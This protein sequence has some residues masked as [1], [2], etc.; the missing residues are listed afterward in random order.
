MEEK[1]LPIGT[2]VQIKNVPKKAMITGY[3]IFS[4]KD[5]GEKIY[6]Y[7]GCPYPVGIIETARTA[8]FNHEDIEKI[9]YLGYSDDEGKELNKFLTAKEEEIKKGI[10]EKL[11]KEQ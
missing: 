2:V 10:K 1:F 6:D 8:V 9:V 7:S 11:S 3:L 5:K 4:E